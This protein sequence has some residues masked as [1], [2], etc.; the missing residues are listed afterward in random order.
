M[1][2]FALTAHAAFVARRG[3]REP[4][5]VVIEDGVITRVVRE[6][7]L[8]TP[9]PPP[10]PSLR[11]T[12][13]RRCS[14]RLLLAYGPSHRARSLLTTPSPTAH[15]EAHSATALGA[16]A[17]AAAA[18]APHHP[19]RDSTSESDSER[20]QGLQRRLL[21]DATPALTLA[22]MPCLPCPAAE[23]RPPTFYVRADLVTPGARVAHRYRAPLCIIA[24]T[25]REQ[26]F[27][28]IHNHGIG[29]SPDVLTYWLDAGAIVT[30]TH[31]RVRSHP[32]GHTTCAE[33]TQQQLPAG[34]VTS[35]LASVVFGADHDLSM[36]VLTN[37]KERV[38]ALG[39]QAAHSACRGAHDD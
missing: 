4:M 11:C 27:V 33:F 31:A 36:R 24:I 18:A 3:R 10:S 13:A 26:G 5:C 25:R 32:A 1:V 30:R 22:A 15:S 20:A 34:G 16:A 2:A 38:G 7:E 9:L 35:L 23:I 17:G 19:R 8:G 37:L 12:H 21:L 28:D 29:G 6:N 14:S 39:R